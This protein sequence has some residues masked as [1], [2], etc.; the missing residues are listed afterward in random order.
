MHIIP[1][2][3]FVYTHLML[4]GKEKEQVPELELLVL[5]PLS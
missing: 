2:S 5:L 4:W 3:M 1:I